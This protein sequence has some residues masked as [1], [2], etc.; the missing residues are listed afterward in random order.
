VPHLLEV[1]QIYPTAIELVEKLL[2]VSS[3]IDFVLSHI[4]SGSAKLFMQ[5]L[6]FTARS[7]FDRAI[8]VLSDLS[9]RVIPVPSCALNHICINANRA[10]QLE[11]FDRTVGLI[12]M[13]DLEIIDLRAEQLKK[14]DN[15]NQLVICA[16]NSDED[17][18]NA[19]LAFS[20]LLELNNDVPRAMQAARKA[21]QINPNLRRAHMRYAELRRSRNDIKKGLGAFTSCIKGWTA[22]R[23]SSC[24]F[25]SWL[26]GNRP[27]SMPPGRQWLLHSTSTAG[28]SP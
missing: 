22:I 19:W 20:R 15:L 21:M 28:H 27:S 18:Q 14:K 16:L 9:H 25:A 4:S 10:E 26:I 7:E 1:L 2:L 8:S 6:Q 24:A 11:P 13:D 23:Q 12:P 3:S 5:S 17:N